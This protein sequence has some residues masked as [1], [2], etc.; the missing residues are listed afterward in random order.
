MVVK[1]GGR[2]MQRIV[3]HSQIAQ[4]Q[5]DCR[6]PGIL[7]LPPPYLTSLPQSW[8]PQSKEG[9]T[10]DLGGFYLLSNASPTTYYWELSRESTTRQRILENKPGML[11]NYR[12]LQ[13]AF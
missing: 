13:F 10:G 7:L 9:L 1:M 2:E 11:A 3:L 5:S 12:Q 8:T 4:G 6:T